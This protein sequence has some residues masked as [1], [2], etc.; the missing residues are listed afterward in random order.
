M[1]ECRRRIVNIAAIPYAGCMKPQHLWPV[2]LQLFVLYVFYAGIILF[3]LFIGLFQ[4]SG[5]FFSVGLL[6]LVITLFVRVWRQLT[7]GKLLPTWTAVGSGVWIG[8]GGGVVLL[9]DAGQLFQSI[10][11]IATVGGIA[12]G[13]AFYA[14]YWRYRSTRSLGTGWLALGSGAWLGGLLGIG[15]FLLASYFLSPRGS[16]N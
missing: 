4:G 2:I 13:V 6:A 5:P 1:S 9:I 8:L 15:L 11:G 16:F 7:T 3:S 12:C 10:G 14:L